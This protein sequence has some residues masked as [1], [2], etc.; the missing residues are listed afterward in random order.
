MGIR[1]MIREFLSKLGKGAELPE[2]LPPPDLPQVTINEREIKRME[3][4]KRD[5]EVR[6]ARL[7]LQQQI[8][9]GR[10]GADDECSDG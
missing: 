6:L 3:R 5:L 10:Y 1:Q 4:E 9:E 2:F 8:A 7:E